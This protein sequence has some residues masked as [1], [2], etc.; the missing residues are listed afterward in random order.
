MFKFVTLF[1]LLAV[2]AAKPGF[3]AEPLVS[4][5]AA[6][7]VVSTIVKSVPTA[8]SHSSSSVVHSSAH[9]AESVVAPVVKTHLTTAP[10]IK[11]YASPIAYAAPVAH[12]YSAPLV[13]SSP[14]S[15]HHSAPIAYSAPLT[16]ASGY[17]S[18]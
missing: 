6:A 7:P 3:L 4:T 18:W 10:V 15:Y 17:S 11:S 14:V 8:V 12:T 1:A 5:Y 13:Y 2:A 16:Y 9:V